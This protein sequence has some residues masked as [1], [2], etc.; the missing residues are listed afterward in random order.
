MCF[1]VDD[2][3]RIGRLEH[4]Q[5]SRRRALEYPANVPPGL[6]KGAGQAWP[7]ADQ[8]TCRDVLTER[9]DGR[10]RI[11]GDQ[12]EQLIL[13]TDQKAVSGNEQSPDLPLRDSLKS[14][15]NFVCGAGAENIELET[16]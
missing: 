10:H 12:R 11:A 14:L 15:V 4:R 1:Y 13:A 3:R 9:I 7:I 6:M 2:H 8:T 5:I 16:K